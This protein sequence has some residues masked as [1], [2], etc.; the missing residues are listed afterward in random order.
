MDLE[1]K[2][3]KFAISSFILG[4]TS[5]I[6]WKYH[7]YEFFDFFRKWDLAIFIQ[8]VGPF[9]SLFAGVV[10][11]LRERRKERSETNWI[12]WLLA[13]AGIIIS[14]IFVGLIC[15]MFLPLYWL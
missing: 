10:A 15:V 3:D 5:A 8:I 7:R 4:V 11:V 2:T 14:G 13:I 9:L 12:N 1:T 6:L